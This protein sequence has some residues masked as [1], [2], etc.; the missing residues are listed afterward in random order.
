MIQVRIK[1]SPRRVEGFL[2]WGHAGWAA[3]GQDIVCAGVSAVVTAAALG[4]ERRLPGG[5]RLA[6][7]QEGVIFC[8]LRRDLPRRRARDGEAILMAMARGL[9]EINR[10]YKGH[11][12][13]AYRR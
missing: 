8:Q 9:E 6:M 3:S 12:H 7:S 1:G 4:L 5:F 10:D 2:V 13:L 11:I